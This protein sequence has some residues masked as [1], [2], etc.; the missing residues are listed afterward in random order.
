MGQTAAMIGG[1]YP[2]EYT[3][4]VIG[5]SS[6]RNKMMHACDSLCCAAVCIDVCSTSRTRSISKQRA[7]RI[8]LRLSIWE[9]LVV[10]KSTMGLISDMK[11]CTS[12]NMGDG[13]GLL[14]RMTSADVMGVVI[15]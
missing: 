5:A 8:W 3:T 6:H 9:Y 11:A 1:K 4:G 14:A 15:G 13:F 2:Y 7:S 10:M 12:S